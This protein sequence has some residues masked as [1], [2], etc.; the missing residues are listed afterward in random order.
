MAKGSYRER[1]PG[2]ALARRRRETW[3]SHGD[4]RQR[5]PACVLGGAQRASRWPYSSRGAPSL[6]PAARRPRPAAGRARVD[7]VRRRRP[8]PADGPEARGPALVWGQRPGRPERGR[9]LRRLP[10]GRHRAGHAAGALGRLPRAVARAAQPAH[11]ATRLGDARRD[12]GA[13]TSSGR[14]RQLGALLLRAGRRACPGRPVHRGGHRADRDRPLH[15]RGRRPARL[16]AHHR[17]PAGVGPAPRPARRPARRPGSSTPRS[18][19][20]AT[21]GSTC[22]TR[23]RACRRRSGWCC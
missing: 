12:L 7:A 5:S 4:R 8:W 6:P 23:P 20:S 14:R 22:S 3:Q 19:P 1:R 16:P 11:R 18:S 17:H 2:G 13:R 21:A 10:R 9:V 15:A